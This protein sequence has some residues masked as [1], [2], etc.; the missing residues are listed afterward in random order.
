MSKWQ[1]GQLVAFQ[2]Y[3]LL[4]V[5]GQNSGIGLTLL[6]LMMHFYLTP[7]RRADGRVMVLA[8][9][10]MVSDS[11]LTWLGV[12]RFDAFPLWLG[13]LWFGFV[14]TLGHSMRWLRRLPWYGLVPVGAVAG[15]ASYMAGWKLG[16]V[17]LPLG[18]GPSSL[19]LLAVWGGLLPLL[20]ALDQSFRRWV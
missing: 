16:A 14:L 7:S 10:G 17:A 6:L 2:A 11:L 20:V 12:F 1:W 13:L 9:I 8:L 3:W 15:M 5:V 4:A 18:P 19:V